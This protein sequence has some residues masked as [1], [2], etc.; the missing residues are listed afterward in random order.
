MIRRLLLLLILASAWLGPTPVLAQAEPGD[1]P[2]MIRAMTPE[3]LARYQH[4]EKQAFELD[5][6]TARYDESAPLREEML[7][8]AESTWGPEHPVTARVMFDVQRVYYSQSRFAD[9]ARLAERGAAIAGKHRPRL[10]HLQLD[11]LNGQRNHMGMMNDLNARVLLDKEIVALTRGLYGE[12]GKEYRSAIESLARTYMVQG[13]LVEADREYRNVLSMLDNDPDATVLARG[14]TLEGYADLL[15]RMYRTQEMQ[16]VQR[17]IMDM[18]E[19]ALVDAD[20]NLTDNLIHYGQSAFYAD[21]ARGIAFYRTALARVEARRGVDHR[22]NWQAM[23]VLSNLLKSAGELAESESLKRRIEA[24]RG[25]Q[26][27]RAIEIRD[28]RSQV[29]LA[30]LLDDQPDRRNEAENLYRAAMASFRKF[31][32]DKTPEY[33]ALLLNM[34]NLLYA[35]QRFD[36]AEPYYLSAMA[37][38]VAQ[39][40]DS[41]PAVILDRL[42]LARAYE[43]VGKS[44]RALVLARTTL[45]GHAALVNA[46]PE[47]AP[48]DYRALMLAQ[49]EYYSEMFVHLAD[50]LAPDVQ[51]SRAP[52]LPDIFTALQTAYASAASAALSDNAARQIAERAGAGEV[53]AAWRAAQ[54]DLARTDEDIRKLGGMV[55]E[56]E[57]PRLA[58]YARRNAAETLLEQRAE[59]LRQRLPALFDV[60][61]P[62]PVPL[63]DL[64]GSDGLLAA[65]EA[66]VIISP[67]GRGPRAAG[68]LGQVMVVT[69]DGADWIAIPMQSQQI[70]ATAKDL[71]DHLQSPDRNRRAGLTIIPED[72]GANA[73]AYW[74]YDR[75]ASYDFHQALFGHPH[76]AARLAKAKRVLLVPQGCL[77]SFAFAALVTRPPPGGP[78]G[79]VDP[80]HLRQTGWLGLE[81]TLV[82]LPSV[83]SLQIAR[84]AAGDGRIATGPARFFGVGDPAYRGT[85]DGPPGN[86]VDDMD[87]GSFQ[88]GARLLAANLVMDRGGVSA[89]QIAALPRLDQSAHEVRLVAE[90]LGAGP[91][92]VLMQMSATEGRVHAMDAKGD[93]ARRQIILLATHGLIAGDFG[94]KLAEPALAFT[95]SN[96]A[97]GAGAA[98][99]ADDDGLLTASEVAA[100]TLNARLVLL[101]ACNTSAGG[102]AGADG[103]SGLARAFLFAGADSL[104][105]THF[106]VRD[107]AGRRVSVA[108]ARQIANDQQTSPADAL[109]S[110]MAALAANTSRDDA[111]LSFA[112]PAVWAPFAMIEAKKRPV[113]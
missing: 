29:E 111:G 82:L 12:N 47:T 87:R 74:R 86:M 70:C 37:L 113:P 66:L 16:A 78:M 85:A 52:L 106:P 41:H 84:A 105:V 40:G 22:A 50:D 65:D 91:K 30:N 15:G 34:A 46:L 20:A 55:M 75:A 33:G 57:A 17:Q 19:K 104:L 94:G 77:V 56:D 68:G 60:L 28:A 49:L 83:A 11:L 72:L 67:A 69:R 13:Q 112:H 88:P 10:D 6:M 27:G 89:R 14:S 23:W 7:K 100:L 76:V 98:A 9:G 108:L 79:D 93:L 36:D 103:L 96:K 71:M 39:L 54:A 1:G 2:P 18:Y 42:N 63:A 64:Q 48:T 61:R 90:A 102:G 35:S 107:E 58:L 31:G 101:S 62:K 21:T 110:A 45:R 99:S 81:K 95:P 8:L 80:V 97:D 25:S 3:E 44:D 53:F 24:M 4:L 43:A 109:R 51:A 92:D 5:R 32:L 26:A 59:Q 73:D 38:N